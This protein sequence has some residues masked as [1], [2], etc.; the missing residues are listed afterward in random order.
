M[1]AIAEGFRLVCQDVQD[2]LMAELP[3]YDALD[4]YYRQ[5]VAEGVTR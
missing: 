2:Q 1:E 5:R 3:V 4:A